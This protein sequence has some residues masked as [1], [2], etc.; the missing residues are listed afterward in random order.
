M[1]LGHL[2]KLPILAGSEV[3]LL[4][5]QG[6]VVAAVEG[7]DHHVTVRMVPATLDQVSLHRGR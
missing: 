3:V 5:W 2:H 7:A 1:V 4:L 6:D